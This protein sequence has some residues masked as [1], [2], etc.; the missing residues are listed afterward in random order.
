[1][2]MLTTFTK[3]DFRELYK[4]VS[5]P[6][7]VPEMSDAAG[8]FM[9]S[10]K[11]MTGRHGLDADIAYQA[12]LATGDHS[13]ALALLDEGVPVEFILAMGEKR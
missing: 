10:L 9:D 1:M 3:D 4:K 7:Y 6:N 13:K 2:T 11:E 12:I 5:D 8:A